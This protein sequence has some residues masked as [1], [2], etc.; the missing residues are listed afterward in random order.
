MKKPILK[1]GIV[2]SG[3]MA[4]IHIRAIHKIKGLQLFGIFSH[5]HQKIQYLSKKYSNLKVINDYDCLVESCDILDIVSKNHT[6]LDYAEK[7]LAYN[8]HIIIEK[9]VDV[10]VEKAR[11]FMSRIKNSSSKVTVISQNRFNEN[12]KIFMKDKKDGRLGEIFHVRLTLMWK[13]GRSYY[14]ANQGWRSRI[15]EAG[16]G[17]LLHQ[18]IHLIDLLL[19]IFGDVKKVYSFIKT[20]HSDIEVEDLAIASM[21]ME[22]GIF[23]NLSFSTHA[24]CNFPF[25]IEVFGTQGT[26]VICGNDGYKLILDNR[27]EKKTLLQK[28][29]YK[30]GFKFECSFSKRLK[31]GTILDQLRCFYNDIVSGQNKTSNFSDAVKTLLCV[32][33]IISKAEK[34]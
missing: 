20:L 28:L 27:C 22:N 34:E 29:F 19:W 13:R 14:E 9:P 32:Y 24:S 18:G 11:C 3:G 16:S 33:Q 25:V 26:A 23:V 5:N 4:E 1:V 8:K 30:A 6:H 12:V 2:G 17:V 10:D 31:E 7:P 15:K 21:L